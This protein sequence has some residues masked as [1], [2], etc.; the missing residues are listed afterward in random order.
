MVPALHFSVA[1][2]WKQRN[3]CED[4]GKEE[5][6]TLPN[7]QVHICCHRH[8]VQIG[9]AQEASCVVARAKCKKRCPVAGEEKNLLRLRRPWAQEGAGWRPPTSNVWTDGRR[10]LCPPHHAMAQE[11][12]RNGYYHSF[13][14]QSWSWTVVNP[15]LE[16]LQQSADHSLL[17]SDLY[18]DIQIK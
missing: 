10:L 16:W 1:T 3:K 5:S 14:T 18:Y 15:D 6:A 8:K 13:C 7:K 11:N 12:S 4:C 2:V 17:A 9:S